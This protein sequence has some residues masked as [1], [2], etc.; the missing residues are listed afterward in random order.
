[1][2]EL[3]VI[4]KCP[5]YSIN[6]SGDIFNNKTGRK[7]K[8]SKNKHYYVH[9]IKVGNKFTTQY[10]HRLIAEQFIP[11]PENKKTVNHKNLN[12]LDNRIDNLEWATYQE[13]IQHA[14]DNG[15]CK[16][17]LIGKIFERNN[18][19]KKIMVNGSIY[20]SIHHAANKTGVDFSTISKIANGKRKTK[21]H[22]IYFI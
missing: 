19:G 11:N 18:V 2:N 12:K 17:N 21:K 5:N 16:S 10:I 9:T 13:N 8:V 3:Y 14:W 6:K 20:K 7:L 15:V 1:M 22:N 4:Q